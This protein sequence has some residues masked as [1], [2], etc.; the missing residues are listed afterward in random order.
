MRIENALSDLF[1]LLDRAALNVEREEPEGLD[2]ARTIRRHVHAMLEHEELLAR[3]VELD[4]PRGIKAE[5]R[6]NLVGLGVELPHAVAGG[7]ERE[8]SVRRE[9]NAGHRPIE[10]R[11]SDDR[12]DPST[13]DAKLGRSGVDEVRWNAAHDRAMERPLLGGRGRAALLFPAL[14]GRGRRSHREDRE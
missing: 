8:A 7:D 1:A 12:A 10:L 4:V 11:L 2:L 3:S 5:L 13:D 14:A 9:P 6:Q